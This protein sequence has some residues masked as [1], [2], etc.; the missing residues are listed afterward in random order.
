MPNPP[1]WRT[2]VSL[3]IWLLP[4]DLSRMGDPTSIYAT[5]GIALRVSGALK[6]HHHDKVE[7]PTVGPVHLSSYLNHWKLRGRESLCDREVKIPTRNF[8]GHDVIFISHLG[9]VGRLL[10][11]R[12]WNAK[13]LIG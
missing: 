3:F 4:L 11:V 10:R 9:R 13:F 7:T 6:P 5:A 1:T 2:R 12:F 8:R